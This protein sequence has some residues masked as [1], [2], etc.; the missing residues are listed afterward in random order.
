MVIA[1]EIWQTNSNIAKNELFFFFL[2]FQNVIK[3]SKSK[4]LES[5]EI[6]D[7]STKKNI[8]EKLVSLQ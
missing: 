5:R 3:I 2:N 4:D 7:Y 1:V 8:S 6:C